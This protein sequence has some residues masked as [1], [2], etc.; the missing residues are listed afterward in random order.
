[1]RTTRTL[2]LVATILPLL[3]T[4]CSGSGDAEPSGG[5]GQGPHRGG[6]LTILRPDR[7]PHLDPQRIYTGTAKS[8][9]DRAV[10]NG[11]EYRYLIVS[12][13][14]AGN[15]SAGVAASALPKR[16]LLRSPKDGAKLKKPPKLMWVKNSEAAYYNVQLFRGSAKILSIWPTSPALT[17]KKAWKYNGRKYALS[18]G[19]YRWY[20]WP[21][22]GT[23]SA[24][25]YG[26]LMGARSFQITR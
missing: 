2:I 16:N 3:A 19:A 5:D 24:V 18:R 25:D 12:V 23:R 4:A 17:L 9:V 15:T 11:L 10:A 8:Y 1:M 21:G 14:K 6:T 26:D 20:V 13:D 7:F 22:F